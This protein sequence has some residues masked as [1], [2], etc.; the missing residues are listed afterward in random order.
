MNARISVP[1]FLAAYSSQYQSERWDGTAAPPEARRISTTR[2][3]A[4]PTAS[5]AA[6]YAG[7]VCSRS[8]A[9]SSDSALARG[10]A[11]AAITVLRKNGSLI[12]SPTALTSSSSAASL[13]SATASSRVG[14][15]DDTPMH[16]SR[17]IMSWQYADDGLSDMIQ[18]GR[19]NVGAGLVAAAGA[20]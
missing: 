4:L 5:R 12:R 8:V 9:C 13:A 7:P 11:Y 10:V 16:I 6:A 2:R 18:A 15:Y 14:R 19:S 3:R 20:G 17:L 1:P